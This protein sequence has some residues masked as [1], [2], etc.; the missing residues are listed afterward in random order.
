MFRPVARPFAR[1][2]GDEGPEF[3]IVPLTGAV[4]RTLEPPGEISAV[5]LTAASVD[6]VEATAERAREVLR[7]ARG[8]RPGRDLE[9][10]QVVTAQAVLAWWAEVGATVRRFALVVGLSALLIA[11]A[12][13]ATPTATRILWSLAQRRRRTYHGSR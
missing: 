5:V 2:T 4:G 3:A 7:E 9:G 12:T 6:S 8:L 11:T 1:V 10:V 13:A